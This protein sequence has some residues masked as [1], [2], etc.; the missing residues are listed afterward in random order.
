MRDAII[1]HLLPEVEPLAVDSDS[2]AES[3]T[4]P[5]GIEPDLAILPGEEPLELDDAPLTGAAPAATP[6]LETAPDGAG[7]AIENYQVDLVAD[8]ELDLLPDDELELD[9]LE[10]DDIVTAVSLGKDP[11]AAEE[12]SLFDAVGTDLSAS[13]GDED[14]A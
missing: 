3:D 1:A 7:D 9:N 4:Q 6:A 13:D 5:L 2:R 12:E 8:E 14:K 11:G 10:G